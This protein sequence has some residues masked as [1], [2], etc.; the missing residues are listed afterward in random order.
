MRVVWVP[1]P[2]SSEARLFEALRGRR[3]GV[4]FRRQV[5]LLGRFIVDLLAHPSGGSSSRSTGRITP[6]AQRP[7]RDG[8]GP[9]L[10]RGI[11][12]C[13]STPSSSCATCR[14][15]LRGCARL[16]SRSR[17]TSCRAPGAKRVCQRSSRPIAHV[18]Y[19]G[20]AETYRARAAP[21]S[22]AS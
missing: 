20:A 7:T 22:R 4:A 8:T 11:G 12:C 10:G 13:G 21:E 2:I 16:S 1:A 18:M 6:R 14:R 5:P 3:L 9:W 19:R 17:A 15:R